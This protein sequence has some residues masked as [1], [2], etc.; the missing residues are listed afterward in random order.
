MRGVDRGRSGR[1]RGV[2]THWVAWGLEPGAGGLGGGEAAPVEGR[3]DFGRAATATRAA[4]RP[5][6]PPPVF[7][8]YALDVAVDL[9]SGADRAKL[10][11]AIEEHVVTTVELVGT[12]ER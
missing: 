3:N 1:A 6:T 8:L 11:R 10:E 9:G 4:A 5:R 12:Y 7:R 2:F